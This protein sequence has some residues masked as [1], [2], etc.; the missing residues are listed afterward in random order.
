MKIRYKNRHVNIN[1]IF[2]FLWLVW[3]FIGVFV[4]AE[5]SWVDYGW[6]IISAIYFGCYSYQRQNKY[7][8]IENGT[9]K[10]NS[11]FSKKIKL[12]DIKQVRKFAGDYILRTDTKELIINT[13]IIESVSLEKLNKELE[14]LKLEWD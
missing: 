14:K 12:N 8:T 2:G 9:I 3:F 6:I 4:K 11:L 7:L 10:I 1:L 5:L 13:S